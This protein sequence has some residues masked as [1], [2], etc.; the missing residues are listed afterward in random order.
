MIIGGL[1]GGD[2]ALAYRAGILQIGTAPRKPLTPEPY[3][4]K[5]RHEAGVAAVAIREGMNLHQPV[6]E[7]HRDLVRWICL[8]LDPRPRVVEQLAQGHGNLMER[9]PEIA[10]AHPEPSC[11]PPY[12]AEHPPVQ[13]LDEFL[14]QR[15]TAAIERP[16]LRAHDVFLLGFVQFAA[17]GDMR[18]DQLAH[19]LR[20][21]R[22][23][24]VRLFEK[25]VHALIPEQPWIRL[26][27][28]FIEARFGV[29]D[30][31]LLVL[32]EHRVLD[33]TVAPPRERARAVAEISL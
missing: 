1:Q 30:R 33:R 31:N 17:I 28:D 25:V 15:I 23:G 2:V 12:V 5:I 14:A 7:A 32:Q 19:F 9:N 4:Q 8:V 10:F 18:G 29:L 13:I 26:A 6:M 20:R 3:H 22:S 21:Q 24:I 11:P 16:V 27:H